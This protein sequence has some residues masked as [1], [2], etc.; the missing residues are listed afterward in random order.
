MMHIKFPESTD[1]ILSCVFS[2]LH[3]QCT[4]QLSVQTDSPAESDNMEPLFIM[5]SLQ[6]II[7]TLYLF[8]VFFDERVISVSIFELGEVSVAHLQ[9][10]DRGSDHECMQWWSDL[11]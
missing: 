10:G 3:W 7:M 2:L 1:I 8:I 5:V 9:S 4:D 11:C 6:Q